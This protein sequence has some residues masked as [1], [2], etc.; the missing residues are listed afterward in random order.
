MK[1]TRHALN[2]VVQQATAKFPDHRYPDDL[3]FA[4]A[5]RDAAVLDRPMLGE[6]LVE[7][8][9]RREQ[10]ILRLVTAGRTN[11]QIAHDLFIELSTVKWY[12][13]QLYR[14]LGVRSPD[15]G[16]CPR[17]RKLNLV[18]DTSEWEWGSWPSLNHRESAGAEDRPQGL[19]AFEPADHRD[20]FGREN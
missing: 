6:N 19:R 14:K 7:Q 8:L 18:V 10:E 16:D 11:Q 2:N 15:A 17:A 12:I 1:R 5:F 20:F 13:N 9:T 4:A 3:A